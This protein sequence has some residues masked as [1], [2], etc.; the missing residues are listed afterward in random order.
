[1]GPG[2]AGVG[3]A[4]EDLGAGAG[5]VSILLL[6]GFALLCEPP[7]ADG[8][9]RG[10]GLGGACAGAH[11]RYSVQKAGDSA[12]TTFGHPTPVTE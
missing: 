11:H 4:F 3:E 9:H 8:R 12:L 1:M 2:A 6:H 7:G 5:R 10:P